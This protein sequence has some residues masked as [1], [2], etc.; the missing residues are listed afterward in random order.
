VSTAW[1]P[2]FLA[3]G[4]LAGLVPFVRLLLVGRRLPV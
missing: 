4:L 3:L 1:V 2:V